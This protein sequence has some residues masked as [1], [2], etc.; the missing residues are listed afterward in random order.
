[1]AI[2][3]AVGAALNP[4]A[5][6]AARGVQHSTHHTKDWRP[7]AVR[8]SAAAMEAGY[9]LVCSDQTALRRAEQ[10][11]QSVVDSLHRGVM[12]I[13]PDNRIESA[14]PASLRILGLPQQYP[15]TGTALTGLFPIESLAH[16]I[17]SGGEHPVTVT[18][19]TGQPVHDALSGSH[20][21]MDVITLSWPHGVPGAGGSAAATA[22]RAGRR[23]TAIPAGRGWPGV[24][25]NRRRA[26]SEGPLGR[27]WLSARRGRCRPVRSARG[28]G[29]R[30]RTARRPPA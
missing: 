2:G 30:G 16:H 19:R 15:A 1:M 13:G 28:H 27:G 10:H 17:L 7:L 3:I 8:V 29:R 11:F 18:R 22:H 20:V 25:G 9:V 26:R 24:A 12:V 5:I 4:A 23:A 21:L 6:V 14:N